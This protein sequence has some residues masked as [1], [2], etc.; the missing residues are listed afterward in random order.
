VQRASLWLALATTVALAAASP[1]QSRVSRLTASP[2]TILRNAD[3]SMHAT[4]DLHRLMGRTRPGRYYRLDRMHPDRAYSVWRG[5]LATARRKANRPPHRSAWL[6]IHRYEGSW[7]DGGGPYYGG[8]QM[9]WG[10]MHAYGGWLLATRGTADHWTP[11]QQMWVAER[12]YRAGRGFFPWPN[13]ARMC[14][15]I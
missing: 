4:L 14:G 8:L 6:C 1:A 9:D 13:T 2:M 3:R 11:L 7:N 10:F 15:L 5:R 12:A